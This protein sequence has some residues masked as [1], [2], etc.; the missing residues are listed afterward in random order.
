MIDKINEN[1]RSN[2]LFLYIF[3]TIIIISI[4]RIT[5]YIALK[6]H[7][8]YLNIAPRLFHLP[9][10]LNKGVSLELFNIT[11]HSMFFYLQL[12]GLFIV[13]YFAY[14]CK[15]KYQKNKHILGEIL[16]IAGGV[17]NLID[18]VV[19]KSVIDFIFFKLPMINNIAICNI[20]DFAITI[21]CFIIAFELFVE[22]NFNDSFNKNGD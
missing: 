11:T 13:C 7:H 21:G 9:P 4:D 15:I 6:Y 2:S 12:L 5:K 8:A 10:L 3:L 1:K 22:K 18:R 17:G 16:I 20:A 14:K 19:Y